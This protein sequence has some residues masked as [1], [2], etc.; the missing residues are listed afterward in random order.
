[1]FLEVVAAT[2]FLPIFGYL[3][4]KLYFRGGLCNSKARLDGKIA[5]ITGANVGIGRNQTFINQNL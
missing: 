1:M 2:I 5:I 3:A 4:N